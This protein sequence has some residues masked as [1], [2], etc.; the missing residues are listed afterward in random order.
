MM[1]RTQPRHARASTRTGTALLAALASIVAVLAV[2][3]PSGEASAQMNGNQFQPGYII[4]DQRFFDYGSMTVGDIQAFLDARGPANCNNCLRV[5]RADTYAQAANP[6]RCVDPIEAKTNI[7]AA[8]IIFDVSQACK[9]NPQVILA[10]LQK[11][12]SLVTLSSPESW[13]YQR[14]MG[15]GCPDTAPCNSDFFGFFFQIYSAA[16]QFQ[17]YS[18]PA[19]IFTYYPIG[20]V[21]NIRLNPKSS[22]GSLPVFIENRA[23]AALYYYTPY[24]PN[25]A[26][27]NNMYGLGDSC[28]AYG[29][30]NFWRTFNDW[31]GPSTPS[32]LPPRPALNTPQRNWNGDTIPDLIGR[33]PD[34]KLYLY[35]GRGGARFATRVQIGNGWHV[36]G[37]M[38]Q[39]HNFGSTGRPEI[40]TTDPV[41]G[42]L[43]LYPG[44]GR[45]GFTAPRVIGNGWGHFTDIIGVQGWHTPGVPGLIAR[46]EAGTLTLYPAAGNAR[47]GAPRVIG[48]GWNTM[49]LIEFG[50]NFTGNG[51]P[52]LIARRAEDSTLWL[53]PGNGQGGFQAPRQIVG[54]D[55]G[56][57]DVIM[58]GADWDRDGRIDIIAREEATGLLWLY[59]G[60]GSGGVQERRQIGNGWVGFDIVR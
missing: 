52:S 56:L 11:E 57:M 32:L 60:N 36:M 9:I 2:V 7:S 19:S 24:Q 47:F 54:D 50:G 46:D 12:M 16:G 17:W 40:I 8:Q 14:A 30:R 18:N 33:D 45:G 58:S 59:P 43:R 41:T 21:S 27:L 42:Q 5:Y 25:A 38:T 51:L 3:A 4:S 10:T 15:Y 34:G 6:N 23:T 39:V 53:Y 26:A 29:N 48:N 55:W 13:R 22:C 20:Q 49:D 31:F 44:N 37:F 35:S 28:S 1:T